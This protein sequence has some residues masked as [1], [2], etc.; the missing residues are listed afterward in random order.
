[1]KRFLTIKGPNSQEVKKKLYLS[2]IFFYSFLSRTYLR[3]LSSQHCLVIL[4]A[5]TETSVISSTYVNLFSIN[6]RARNKRVFLKL[7]V[8]KQHVSIKIRIL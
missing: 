6:Q 4:R 1:M 2:K 7:V 5:S 3:C 8:A